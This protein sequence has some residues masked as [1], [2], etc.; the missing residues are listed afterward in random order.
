[1]RNALFALCLAAAI[2]LPV[3]P[4]STA[5]AAPARTDQLP[6]KTDTNDH[7]AGYV[8][9]SKKPGYFTE[10][11]SLWHVP[12]GVKGGLLAAQ[13]ADWVGIDGYGNDHIIQVGTEVT[14]NH[15]V[16]VQYS[17]WYE[18]ATSAAESRK[19]L[20]PIPRKDMDVHPGDLIEGAVQELEPNKWVLYIE[21]MTTK[22][23][24]HKE[25]P[26]TTPGMTAEAIHENPNTGGIRVLEWEKTTNVEFISLALNH[27]PVNF[28][29]G[30][31]QGVTL[32]Q[33]SMVDYGIHL[34]TPSKLTGA[35]FTV[36][37]GG[38]EPAAPS[39]CPL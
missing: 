29:P 32:Y 13:A 8:A 18:M 12:V 28:V 21:D 24:W 37:D 5:S 35:C 7:W 6:V 2:L 11:V 30:Y 33:V 1:M 27:E 36:A 15:T 14:Y 20:K 22:Q 9:V 31:F 26:F 19:G 10:V 4:S 16:G 3:V 39:S 38:T 23:Q 34:A 17:A 25:A